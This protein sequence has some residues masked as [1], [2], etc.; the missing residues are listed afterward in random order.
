MRFNRIQ[1]NR[2]C[3]S[4]RS[5]YPALYRSKSRDLT[6][7]WV[8]IKRAHRPANIYRDISYWSVLLYHPSENVQESSSRSY[9]SVSPKASDI[10]LLPWLA[11]KGTVPSCELEIEFEHHRTITS[12]RSMQLQYILGKWAKS[13]NSDWNGLT[14]ACKTWKRNG[15]V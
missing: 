14:C 1:Q 9:T 13:Y 6:L 11:P 2:T 3:R 12:R 10:L 7:I 15:C 4:C 5:S 8:F